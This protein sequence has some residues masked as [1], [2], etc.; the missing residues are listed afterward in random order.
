M[1]YKITHIKQILKQNP[2]IKIKSE[3][4]LPKNI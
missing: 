4:Y 2:K 1:I 3:K